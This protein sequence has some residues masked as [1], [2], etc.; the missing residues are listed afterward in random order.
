MEPETRPGERGRRLLALWGIAAALSCAP[1]SAG[2]NVPGDWSAEVPS[3]GPVDLVVAATTDVHGRIRGWDYLTNRAETIR[4]LTRAATIVDSLRASAPGRVI[5]LD[6]GDLLQG[7]PFAYTVYQQSGK[8]PNAI[9]AAMNAMHYDAA[10]IGNHEFNYGIP[11]LDRSIA[12]AT[13]PFLSDNTYRLDG[14]HAY[15]PWTIIERAGIKVGVIGATTPGVV[16]WDADNVR[17]KVT[18]GDIIPAV[19]QSVSEVKA[20]GANVVIV[21]VHSGLDERSSYDTVVTRVPSENVAA[22]LAAEVPGIDLLLYGH[23]HKEMKEKFI[24]NTLLMQPKNWATSVSVAHLQVERSTGGWTVT[25]KC[26]ELVQAAGHPESSA[27]LSL[28][29]RIHQLT[30]EQFNSTIGTTPVA[31]PGALSRIEDTPILDF[32]LETERKVS[33]ADL[34]SSAAFAT[35][36][37]LGPG[38]VTG[39]QIVHLYP[40][41]NTLRVIRVSGKQ[42]RQYLDF[43]SRYYTGRL[44]PDGRLETDSLVASYNFDIVAG[45]DYTIDLNQPIG[46]RITRLEYKG[47]PVA[48]SDSFSLALSN[49]RQ[50]GGGGY[51]M[52]AGTRVLKEIATI[53]P[54]MLMEEVKRKGVIKPEDYFTLNWNIIPPAAATVR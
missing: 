33:G 23:S 44:R 47:K 11:Y 41:D 28:S 22:R 43:S 45:V 51:S 9:I 3:S 18:L 31:W 26:A 6:A 25:S 42:L 8:E 15:R 34:A 32:V 35:D 19:R 36:A 54:Q 37:T 46:A 39:A 38:A 12:E 21:S 24:G 49:Y 10:A 16:L 1:S 52:I 7:N 5:L 50:G 40:Y 2:T 13:F 53:V 20:A 29:D 14:T 48:D 27:I 17:G 4:G 30:Y